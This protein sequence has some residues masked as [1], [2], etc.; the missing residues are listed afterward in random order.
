M[1]SLL[2]D[3]KKVFKLRKTASHKKILFLNSNVAIN[4][5]LEHL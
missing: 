4:C 5:G 1:S 2:V 3:A